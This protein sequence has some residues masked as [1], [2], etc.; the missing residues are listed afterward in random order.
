MR[1]EREIKEKRKDTSQSLKGKKRSWGESWKSSYQ[2]KRLGLI[3]L[4]LTNY[5][6]FNSLKLKS[7][8]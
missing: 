8:L 7:K 2:I 4:S 1:R 6:K 3:I 5:Y